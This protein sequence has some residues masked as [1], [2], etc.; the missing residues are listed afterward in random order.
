MSERQPFQC[1]K[2]SDD[3]IRWASQLLGLA[4]DAFCGAD[5]KD[6]RQEI[7]KSF[8]QSDIAACPGSG[9]TTLLVAKLAILAKKW[10]CRTRG[11]CVL[12]HTN[13]ARNEIE[14][15]LGRTSI[16][17]VLLSYP[18]FIGTIHGFVNEYLAMPWLR[19]QGH[20]IKMVDTEICEMR[21]WKKIDRGSRWALQQR[22][23]EQSDI[24]ITDT[25]CNWTK[26]AGPCRIANHTPTYGHVRDACLKTCEEGYY[27][28]DDMFLWAHDIIEKVP[29]IVNVIR[30][31]F[32]LLFVDEAQDNSEDQ[33]AILHRIFMACDDAVLR[34]RFGDENQAIFDGIGDKDASTDGF[35]DSSIRKDV[36]NSPRF[37]QKI[38]DFAGPLGVN[39]C[40]LRGNGPKYSLS[41][42]LPEARHTIFLFDNGGLDKVLAAYAELLMDMFSEQ[43]LRRGVFSAV[44]Q[45]HRDNDDS[46]APHHV[47]HYWPDYDPVFTSRDPRPK[48]FVQYVFAGM[49]K[50]E[51]TGETYPAV[52]KIA[53]GVLR[54]ARMV[55]GGTKVRSPRHSHRYIWQLLEKNPGVQDHYKDMVTNFAVKREPLDKKAWDKS[56]C[57]IVREIAEVAGGASLS[58]PD[59][60]QFLAW[61]GSEDA[62]QSI[63]ASQKKQGNTFRY[64]R[65]GKDVNIVVG[66]IHSVKGQ[67]HTA[68]LVLE[69]F[70]QDRRGRHNLELLL[71]WLDGRELGGGSCGPQQQTR[72]KIHYVAMT[73]PTHLLCLAMKRSTFMNGQGELDQE[74]VQRLEQR[75]WQFTSL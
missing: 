1:P 53:E 44:G 28:Y 19:S 31:R 46:H 71:R 29:R 50:S 43:E 33:S 65:D 56:W 4:D 57:C 54:L 10:T 25:D 30:D 55:D 15:L 32:P 66:S 3:D 6:P 9:K 18:H 7:L 34:Q 74:L 22:R 36:P 75:G 40:G 24:R 60:D 47:G 69:T 5:G 13:A 42:G 67:T 14:T 51:L 20:T 62:A 27:C 52:E 61:D 16:G 35:P 21:R 37:G 49:G 45:V 41:S 39:P 72:L 38:A 64:H 63:A 73:R 11:I 12:S 59:A 26:K 23:I 70:W 48:T 8:D 17:H 68:T 2:I 58:T